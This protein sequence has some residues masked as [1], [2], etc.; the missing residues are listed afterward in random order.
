M[1]GITEPRVY[2]PPLRELTEETSLGFDVIRFATEILCLTLVPWQ[3]WLFIHMFEIIGSFDGEWYF[4]FRTVVVIIARQNGKTFVGKILAAY[5]LYVFGVDLVLG[6]AQ[7]IDQAEDTWAETVAMIEENEQLACE[8]EHV[9]YTNG[10]KRLS[11]TDGRNYR[12]KAS[13]RRAGR[14]KSGDFVMLDELREHQD[15]QAW[16]A[17]TKTTLARPM[18]LVFCMSN[19]GDGTSVV[20]R[21][22]RLKA[23]NFIGDP[24]GI[25]KAM[26]EAAIEPDEDDVEDT[27]LGLFE[28]S[29]PPEADPRDPHARAQANPS[30]GYGFL[31]ERSLESAFQT[32][33][34]DVFLT[35]CLCQW[36]TATVTP[37]F[38]EGAWQLGVDNSSSIAPD[39][40][41]FF[42]VDVSA[43]RMHASIAACGMRADR[44]WHGELVAYRSGIAWLQDW[45]Q[46]YA[47][48][49][50]VVVAMQGKGAPV[51]AFLE[52]LGAIDGVSVIPCEGKDLAAWAGRMWDAVASCDEG[53]E[54]DTS[55][56]FHRVQPALDLAAQLAATRPL[57]DG[58]WTWD[59]NKS[60]EDI[61]PLV[62]LTMAYGLATQVR[63]KPRQSAYEEVD[64]VEFL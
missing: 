22:L 43:D 40:E 47:A 28:W 29:A 37:P 41:V 58:A 56:I 20:L 13:S 18:A 64:G 42:G 36:V 31:T 6:T 30:M 44:S 7:S 5:F 35:E 38:P 54:S 16:A 21:H 17:I 33:P 48:A 39:A 52:I 32:D 51:S 12:V 8:I 63:E 23:H 55:P 11:L 15:F 59:R 24:D 50:P 10:S 2:T 9:W 45:F 25:V 34:P 46:R 14:G 26:G 19:A 1:K 27:T 62:A 60:L 4:R 57:G 3:R 49:H 53:S 61:S